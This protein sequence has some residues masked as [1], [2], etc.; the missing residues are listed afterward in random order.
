VESDVDVWSLLTLLYYRAASVAINDDCCRVRAFLL[1][2]GDGGVHAAECVVVGVASRDLRA[3]HGFYVD[4]ND[5]SQRSSN[6]CANENN[7]GESSLRRAQ[8]AGSALMHNAT[9]KIDEAIRR[10]Y[11]GFEV[12]AMV[13]AAAE[14][15]KFSSATKVDEA[16]TITRADSGMEPR[17]AITLEQRNPPSSAKK[18]SSGGSTD[19]SRAGSRIEAVAAQ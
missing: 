15:Q 8:S 13:A 7:R 1:P 5:V 11:S 4:N 19:A 17:A 3:G 16:T 6:T 2:A 12:E 10:A 18:S 9:K 14:Q